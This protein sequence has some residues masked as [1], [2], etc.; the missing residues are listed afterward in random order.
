MPQF[1]Y[2]AV[3]PDR[4]PVEGTVEAASA[5][6]CVA[7]LTEQGFRVNA[8]EPLQRR[9]GR[10][11]RRDALRWEDVDLFNEQLL[12]ITQGGLPLASSLA[13]LAN[14]IKSKKLQD[15]TERLC[16]RL[17][18]GASL[19]EAL[20]SHPESFPPMYRSIVR[21]GERSGNLSGV[22]SH[23]C[24]Y[25]ARMV[26]LKHRLHEILAYPILVLVA[27]CA[28]LGLV[29]TKIVPVFMGF[30]AD[31]NAELPYPTR[32]LAYLSELACNQA[33]AFVFGLVAGGVALVLL[34]HILR[35]NLAGSD[36]LDG[37]LLRL[38]VFGSR[39]YAAA[40]ARFSRS[41]GMLLTNEIPIIESMA[42]AA[43]AA[44]NAV[45][46]NACHTAS[47][48]IE[49]GETIAHSLAEANFF[50]GLYCWT[51]ENAERSGELDTALLELA[52]DY[53]KDLER[54]DK[55]IVAMAG[56]V[57]LLLLGVLIGFIVVAL[58]LPIESL[59]GMLP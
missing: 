33:S 51:L 45:L 17:N 27:V 31:F 1:T 35:S 16:T 47:R 24:T 2:R 29:L 54:K 23:L 43:E 19:S 44:N 8:V 28:V 21:A 39:N 11:A 52:D 36:A 10:F 58:Y 41:L 49:N 50:P 15:L 22:L 26:E 34:I 37:L 46:R 42:L 5:H 18:S 14:D 55:A 59:G 25:S 4:K 9:P 20:D 32:I 38:P 13:A 7:T 12:T 56:P 40:I 53:E 6:A 57:S 3:N 30:Y 48:R